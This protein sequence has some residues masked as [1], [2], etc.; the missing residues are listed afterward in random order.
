MLC[1]ASFSVASVIT[2]EFERTLYAA[3]ESNQ[4]YEVCIVRTGGTGGE[5][6]S[7]LVSVCDN[8]DR[9]DPEVL[10]SEIQ[11]AVGSGMFPDYRQSTFTVNMLP[12]ESRVCVFGSVSDDTL[13]ENV[14]AFDICLTTS[15]EGVVVGQNDRASVIV[16][17]N[18]GWSHI[19][20][21]YIE[22][23]ETCIP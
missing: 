1:C 10:D 11:E 3:F 9:N 4:T 17:D 16:E 23:L 7:A 12:N 5:S 22:I 8:F 18:D 6:V 21:M 14:E 19:C 13:V 15:T 2:I 20:I